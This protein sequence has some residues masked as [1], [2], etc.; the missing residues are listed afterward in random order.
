MSARTRANLIG[1]RIGA[2]VVLSET[3]IATGGR[4]ITGLL[5][6]CD[7]GN[8]CAVQTT[9]LTSG[10]SKQCKKCGKRDPISGG[11]GFSVKYGREHRAWQNMLYRC[12]KATHPS[13]HYYGGRGITVCDRWRLGEDHKH[14]FVC[15]M[16]DMGPRPAPR[17]SI[18]RTNNE[19]NYEP[20]NCR[21]ATWSQQIKNR[22]KLTK[23]SA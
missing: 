15:F 16:D 13:Y 5:C 20:S 1:K 4:E 9:T 14:P 22:R 17:L 18:D 7:C 8:I 10:D 21:W 19:G 3:R 6:K 11:A 23:R 2:W 12:Y